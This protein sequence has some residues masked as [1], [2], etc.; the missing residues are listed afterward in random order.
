MIH[1]GKNRDMEELKADFIDDEAIT[2]ALEAG[3]RVSREGIK[4]IL[5]KAGEAKGLD[6]EDVA[7]LLH[8][9][10]DELLEEMYVTSREIKDRIYGNR[11]VIFAPLYYSDYCV[12]N[13]R[14]CGYRRDNR[15]QRRRLTMEEVRREVEILEDMG[16]KRLALEAGEDPVNCPIEY[17]LEV[18]RTVY[19]TRLKNGSIRRVNVN[20]AATTV[21]NYR[22]L[23]E[24]GIGT[25]ILFQE[26]YH[27]PTYKYMHPSGPKSDY[28][29]HTTA[30]DRAM[31]GGIDDVGLG[32]LFGLYD[33]KYE[34]L[35]LLQHARHLEE[36]YGVGPHTIS[37]PR[38]RP[39]LGVSVK[40]FPYLVSDREFKKIVAIVRLAVPYTG[41][42]LSTRERPDFREEVISVGISQISAGS[43]TGVG[44]Y[45]DEISRRNQ[46]SHAQF[47]V[48]DHRTPNEVLLSLCEQGYLPSYCTACYRS[49]RTGDRFMQ[50]AKSGNI[51]NCCQPNAILTFKEFLMD[52]ADPQLKE[53]GEKVIKKSLEDIPNPTV[54]QKTLDRLARIEQGDRDLFF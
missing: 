37:F 36:N 6:L 23:K 1:T 47:Q 35:A 39:A 17:T 5:K 2:R 44:G 25:Y 12:N 51:H 30:M 8:C 15:T 52:Y 53:L 46:G 43:C 26:T 27:R 7:A 16:H 38:I 54:K 20:I 50:L 33:Y 21:E 49:G 41:M 19:D 9:D 28:D 29:Y 34:V 31:A 11:I 13:C 24:A 42:I 22:K 45:Y 32:V 4:D 40:D 10:D 3:K 48:E 14:Y 18:I